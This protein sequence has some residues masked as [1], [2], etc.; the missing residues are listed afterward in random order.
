LRDPARKTLERGLH[1]RKKRINREKLSADL[2]ENPVRNQP[3]HPRFCE[4]QEIKLKTEETK[5]RPLPP[6]QTE[7]PKK[8]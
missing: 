5:N 6:R 1:L 7:C 2:T 8:L 3:G 4:K